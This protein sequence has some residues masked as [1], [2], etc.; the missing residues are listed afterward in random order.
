MHQTEAKQYILPSNA[1]R[2]FFSPFFPC[3]DL[4]LSSDLLDPLHYSDQN[5]KK[6]TR[7]SYWNT[8]TLPSLPYGVKL[9]N[10]SPHFQPL[11]R[12]L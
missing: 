11:L 3:P 9:T 10:S 12:K 5:K 4:D 7:K 6:N 2:S 1:A 8:V